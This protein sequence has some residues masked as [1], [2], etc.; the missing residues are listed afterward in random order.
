VKRG[1]AC[2]A[3][4]GVL[5]APATADAAGRRIE[6][7]PDYLTIKGV[8]LSTNKKCVKDQFMTLY[9][10]GSDQQIE[11]FFSNRHGK[12]H[13]QNALAQGKYVVRVSKNIDPNC[14]A[15]KAVVEITA[16]R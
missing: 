3:A 4:I 9:A 5:I 16:T 7:V 13:S 11:S 8:I 2:V 10:K 12:F 1:I 14:D 6:A 15:A